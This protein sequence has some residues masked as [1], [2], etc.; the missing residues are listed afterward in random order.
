MVSREEFIAEHEARWARERAQLRQQR[1]EAGLATVYLQPADDE[2]PLFS[3]EYQT[4]FV[5][6]KG[7]LSG[8][9]VEAEAP[10]MTMDSVDA[11]GGYIGEL[12]IPHSHLVGVAVGVILGAWL[13]R[14]L[15][16]KIRVQ[17]GDKTIEATTR[18]ALTADELGKLL[19]E[20][21]MTIAENVESTEEW[22]SAAAA[23]ALL[24][25]A[26]PSHPAAMAIC[27]RAHAGMIRARAA[28]FV[29]ADRPVDNAELPAEF[30]WAEGHEALKQDWKTGDFE[31]W[32]DHKL[33][34]RAF[35]V[36][37]L[38]SQ[39]EKLIPVA[40]AA[41]VTAT[42]PA[43]PAAGGRPRADWW[44]D[45]WV[46]MCR[47]LYVGDL[48]PKKQSDIEQAMLSWLAKRGEHPSTSTIRERARKLWAA[49]DRDEN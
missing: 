25:P 17:I 12:L 39:I 31:T 40:P 29:R 22:I 27:A 21:G 26:M 46:E 45:L 42:P 11:A 36:S 19:R 8:I 37:F 30:W 44:D 34:L 47:Q 5:D 10:F 4:E 9:G 32:I 20:A 23:I 28:R 3:R 13:H 7:A 16:R 14:R 48:K 6:L 2:P 49:I 24:R 35:D 1:K 43:T 18:E 15:G 38:R 41:A 33:H